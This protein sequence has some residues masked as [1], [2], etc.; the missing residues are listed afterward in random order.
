MRK[1]LPSKIRNNMPS[2]K[3]YIR[4]CIL[5]NVLAVYSGLNG[6]LDLAAVIA[7]AGLC[8]FQTYLMAKELEKK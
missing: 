5:L 7:F 8:Q 4:L 1:Y 6:R 2:S 3:T